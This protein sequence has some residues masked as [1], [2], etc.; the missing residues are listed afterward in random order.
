MN[1][2]LKVILWGKEIGRLA[3]DSKRHLSYFTFNPEIDESVL[4]I[5]PLIA[6]TNIRMPI[7]GDSGRIYQK[8]P[9]FLADSLPDTWGNL[10][11]ESWRIEN[12]IANADI[13]PLEKLSFIGKRGMGALEY[14]PEV[15]HSTKNNKIDIEALSK[16][17]QKIYTQRESVHILPEESL[18]LQALIA[19]GTSAGGRQPKAIV[20]INRKTG[21]IR[22]GQVEGLKGYD[23]D[24]IKFG[25]KERSSAEL[26][27]TYY[28]MATKAGIKMMDSKT[29]KIENGIH[30]MTKRFDRDGDNKLHTQTLAAIYPETDSYEKLLWVCRKMRLSEKD[31]EEVYRRMIFNVVANNTDDHN[32]NFSFIM[33]QEGKWKLSP[34]YDMTFIFD[35]GG[36]LPEKEHCLM[37]RGKLSDITREDAIKFAT[38]NGIRKAESIIR[39][40]TEAIFSFRAIALKNGVKEE[41]IGRVETCLTK[42]LNDWGIIPKKAVGSYIDGSG[43][44]ICDITIEQAYHGN[45]HII[46]TV[47]GRRCKHVIRK[48]TSEHEKIDKAG[49]VNITTEMLKRL[50]NK[51]LINEEI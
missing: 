7:Y 18:T 48:G 12:K 24:I 2:T 43:H 31:A 49:I 17:A 25:N 35:N 46:A 28:E 36:Y 8:L 40:V 34:A 21:E 1:R 26:E 9:P 20:A 27:M 11:F 50:V 45:Y 47:D 19:V 37:I 39:E 32:K 42:R 16:L 14:E 30:F 13:T 5:A 23:Y 41:W 10:L 38:E 29:L 22:S 44:E 6:S 33:D 4:N 51:Y 15:K 3:W